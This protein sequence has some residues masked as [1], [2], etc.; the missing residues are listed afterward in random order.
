MVSKTEKTQDELA[1]Y[2]R[3]HIKQAR[4][5]KRISQ[6]ELGK[7]IEKTNVTI[8]DIERGKVGVTA[9][10]LV[11]IAKALNKPLGYFIPNPMRTKV[12]PDG[13]NTYEEQL[14]ADFRSIDYFTL[15]QIILEHVAKLASYSQKGSV[16]R[17]VQ[18]ASEVTKVLTGKD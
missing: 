17:F 7:V 6:E 12:P 2:I 1:T 8:S 5:E 16:G 14:L 10:D 15:Q 3:Q 18:E 13:L 9:V 11:M 4:E